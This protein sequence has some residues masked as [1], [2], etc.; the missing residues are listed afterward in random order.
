MHSTRLYL[1]C[2][3][4]YII[5]DKMNAIWKVMY[6]LVCIVVLIVSISKQNIPLNQNWWWK[7][8]KED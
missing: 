8:E 6:L 1:L 3:D 7:R 5:T 2:V 4:Y